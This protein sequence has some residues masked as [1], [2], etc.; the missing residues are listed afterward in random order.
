MKPAMLLLVLVPIVVVAEE[1]DEFSRAN[2]FNNE[3][4]TYDFF[5]PPKQMVVISWHTDTNNG[6]TH[7]AGSSDPIGCN[8]FLWP[9]GVPNPCP[10]GNL[11][12]SSYCTFDQNCLYPYTWRTR[13]AGIHN[14]TDGVPLPGIS[15]RWIVEGRHSY[16]L[17]SLFGIPIAVI[18]NTGPE[19]DCNLHFDQFY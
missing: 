9:P 4:I 7:Y 12:E 1:A 8:G 16:Y 18:Q 15:S 10:K 14:L 19:T 13:H 6:V 3:S 11:V 17:G 5:A 2:C